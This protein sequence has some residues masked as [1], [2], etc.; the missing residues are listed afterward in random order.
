MNPVGDLMRLRL[1][2]SGG[3]G[4]KTAA[5]PTDDFHV[6]MTSWPCGA[7]GDITNFDNIDALAQGVQQI[8]QGLQIDF[9]DMGQRGCLWL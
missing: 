6:R 3:L 2:L 7:C 5:V 9:A 1:S 4:V 8:Y